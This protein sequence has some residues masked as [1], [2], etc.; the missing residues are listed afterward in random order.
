MTLI[1]VH[2]VREGCIKKSIQQR[3]GDRNCPVRKHRQL[4]NFMSFVTTKKSKEDGKIIDNRFSPLNKK[5]INLLPIVRSFIILRYTN[6]D[7]QSASNHIQVQV[8]HLA[9]KDKEHQDPEDRPFL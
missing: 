1:Y 5:G 2:F 3:K 9:Q 7:R 8:D 4:D 6:C